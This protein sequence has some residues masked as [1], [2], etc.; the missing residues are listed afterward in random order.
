[1]KKKLS[2]AGLI[3]TKA[4][5]IIALVIASAAKQS[6]FAQSISGGDIHSLALCSDS[7]VR[8]WGNNSYG[9]LGNGN[10]TDSNVPV[11]VTGLCQ[12]ITGM[13]EENI[14]ST[15]NIFPNPFTTHATIKFSRE[16]S[17]ACLRVYNM[18]GEVVVE[19]RN[20]SGSTLNITRGNLAGG[21]Y[22]YEVTEKEKKICGGKAVVY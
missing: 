17:A 8:G 14:I 7:T 11:Q 4:G 1:M 22:V 12:M 3:P 9:Q 10:N 16:L 21:V 2:A 20:I 19:Q 13:E 6:A 18:F 5:L 15:A